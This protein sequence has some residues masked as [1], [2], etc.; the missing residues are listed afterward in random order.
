MATYDLTKLVKLNALKQ[1][2]EAIQGKYSTTEE[3]QAAISTAIAQAGHASFEVASKVPNASDAV[4]NK[5]YLVMNDETHH[6]DIY[7]KIGSEV[8][9]L[10]DTTVDLTNYIEK[11]EGY[12][13]YPDVDKTK[14]AGIDP[15]ANKYEHPTSDAGAKDEGFYK[16][17]TDADGHVIGATAVE[18]ADITKLGIPEKDTTYDVATTTDDG[19]MSSDD[20][21]KLD[22]M[23]IASD[24]DVQNMLN[25]IFT[26]S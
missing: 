3:M 1:L 25:D 20:K 13:L 7:A 23:E 24:T 6:Y 16:V 14:L 21:E 15:Q 8:L 11:Q 12:G 18:K 10:D 2:A 22:G 19:L 4:E 5:L 26:V 17:T 9:R